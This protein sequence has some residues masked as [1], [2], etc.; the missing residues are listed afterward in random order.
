LSQ[1]DGSDEPDYETERE[2]Y[3]DLIE[4]LCSELGMESV[5]SN[6][7]SDLSHAFRNAGVILIEGENCY[8]ITEE[9]SEFNHI[10]IAVIPNFKLEDLQEDIYDP[11]GEMTDDEKE[12]K[13]KEEWKKN[14]ESFREEASKILK[15]LKAWY[16]EN[17]TRRSGPW[18][19]AK[20]SDDP[21]P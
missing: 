19:T 17:M 4:S 10:P 14:F 6:S 7:H 1:D 13:A 21:E 2:N 8:I 20:V 3:R 5:A 15:K 18:Q 16:G 12:E 11:D 9:G